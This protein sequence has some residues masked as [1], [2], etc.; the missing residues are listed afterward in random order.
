MH[1]ELLDESGPLDRAQNKEEWSEGPIRYPP[2]DQLPDHRLSN[3][4]AGILLI[5]RDPQADAMLKSALF[6][7]HQGTVS[8]I[9]SIDKSKKHDI[10]FRL[11]LIMY[12]FSLVFQR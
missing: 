8:D 9:L 4:A 2:G 6:H 11:I 5:Q 1:D 3:A 10:L 7:P 12:E